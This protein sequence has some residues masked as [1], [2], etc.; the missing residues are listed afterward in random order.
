MVPSTRPVTTPIL[1]PSAPPKTDRVR[2]RLRL[3]LEPFWV[4]PATWSVLSVVAGL[5]IPLLDESVG[6]SIP[7]LFNGS[8]DSARTLLSTTAGAMISVTGLVFSITIVVLQLA[9]SQ[10]SPRVL[11]TFL[12]DRVT[13]HTLGVFSAS[14]LYALTVIRSLSDIKDSVPQLAVTVSFFLVLGAVGMFLAFIHHI[15]QSIAVSTVIHQ[16]GDQTRKLLVRSADRRGAMPSTPPELSHLPEQSVVVAPHTGYLN[17]LDAVTLCALARQHDVRIEI[18]WPLGSFLPEGSPL[19]LI[20]GTADVAAADWE[21]LTADGITLARERSMEQDLSYGFR[22]L[23][24]IAERALSP[25]TNDPTTAV[26]ALDELHD[27]LRRMV[28]EPAAVGVQLDDAGVVRLVTSEWTFAQFLDLAVD[29]IAHWG[30]SS[31]QIPQRL[32]EMFN[33][34]EAAANEENKPTIRAKAA[35]IGASE[36][37]N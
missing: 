5:G 19:A 4:I 2:R 10:F 25:G 20:H 28:G 29:E 32:M 3:L 22:R 15:T 34:L 8:I 27:I 7:L 18:L 31:L 9:S 30:S 26:Q 33:D 6:K 23:V 13:Q 16:A 35:T 17:R 1:A 21:T 14:F 37:S 12:Q 24:D 36:T 11:Q